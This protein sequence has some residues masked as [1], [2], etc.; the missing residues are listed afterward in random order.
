MSVRVATFNVENL[1]ARYK[2][3]AKKEPTKGT[4]FDRNA[5]AFEEFTSAEKSIT[6]QAVKEVNAD[7]I[8]LQ[9]VESLEVLDK[10]ASKYLAKLTYPYHVL[11]DS[12]DPRYID[13]AVLSRYP[14]V[15]VLTHR[16]ERTSTGKAWLFSRDCLE[17][18]VA[19]ADKVLSLYVN[20]FKSMMEGRDKTMPRRKEQVERVRA[21]VDERWKPL[22]H[23]GNF[24]VLGDF[25]D[26]VNGGTS[27]SSLVN[28]PQLVNVVDRL[29]ESERWTHYY[30]AADEYRQLDFLLPSRALADVNPGAPG[31]MRK[32]M[33]KRATRY[34]GQ[35]FAGVGTNSPKASDHAPVYWDMDLV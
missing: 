17:V 22:G 4:E 23:H 29:P 13:V 18:D 6:G 14:F 34:T 28:H 20:H 3:R 15:R 21:I 8:C 26:Y 35:R 27:L 32:G 12:H 2:F 9:E 30:A 19:V 16:H 33:P 24:I 25:N 5:L 11:I 1:F 7:I 31:I 10:F